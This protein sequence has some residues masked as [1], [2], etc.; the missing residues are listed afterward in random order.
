MKPPTIVP[1]EK[2][3]QGG[4]GLA[5]QDG[6]RIFVQDTVPDE[7]VKIFA[8]KSHKQFPIQ[9]PARLASGQRAVFEHAFRLR[10]AG[11]TLRAC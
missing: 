3:V 4:Y 8:G 1:I 10:L 7:T 9:D 6:R 5:Q 11:V 2:L